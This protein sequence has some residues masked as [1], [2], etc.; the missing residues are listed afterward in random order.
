MYI[1]SKHI[2]WLPFKNI[3][4]TIDTLEFWK[5]KGNHGRTRYRIAMTKLCQPSINYGIVVLMLF[6]FFFFFFFNQK[7][8]KTRK[9]R[10]NVPQLIRQCNKGS[11]T[12]FSGVRIPCSVRMLF[13][14]PSRRFFFSKIYKGYISA[15]FMLL[16]ITSSSHQ[17][18]KSHIQSMRADRKV[19]EGQAF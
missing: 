6:F 12:L 19:G 17:Y 9:R 13:H 11:T 18:L 5:E 10:I 4:R 16:T 15:L 1:N 14:F 2:Y 7:R 3:G 8:D